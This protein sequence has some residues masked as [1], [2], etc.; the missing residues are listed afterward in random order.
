MDRYWQKPD[1][2]NEALQD[3][4][5]LTNDLGRRTAEGYIEYIG[6]ADDVIISSGYRI[7]PA[8][9]ERTLGTHDAVKAA[10]VVGIPDEDR[11]EIPKAVVVL[12][13]ACEAS[14]ELEEAL[15]D[16]VKR[17]LA[18]HKYPRDIEFADELPRTSTGKIQREKLGDGP[19][20][21]SDTA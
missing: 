3:G 4:W 2:T 17:A 19:P 11:G 14:G 16:H 1:A 20:D 12:T 21:S 10:G 18:R 7:G 13:D 9:I 5:L 15:Q 6:R 8:E